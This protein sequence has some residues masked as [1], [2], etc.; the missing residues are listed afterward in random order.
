[1]QRLPLRTRRTFTIALGLAGLLLCA[2]SLVAAAQPVEA[3]THA[4]PP[5]EPVHYQ[6]DAYYPPYTFQSGQFLW[7]FDPYL[8][9]I[10]F[11]TN[12]FAL[13]WS[14]AA[15]DTVYARV[16]SGEI[17]IAGI[18]AITDERKQDVL[19]SKPLFN[20]YV[21]VYTTQNYKTITME[22]LPA[23]RIGVGKGYYTETVLRDTLGI[24]QYSAFDNMENALDA[25]QS[26]EIDVI[27]EN[28]QLM[29]NILIQRNLKGSIVAQITN[30]FP[31]PHAYAISKQKPE[32]VTFINERL[33]QLMA[34]GVFEEIYVKY[35]YTHSDTY[36]EA[37]NRRTLYIAGGVMLAIVSILALMQLI[38]RRLKRSLSVS[39]SNVE[40]ANTQL[41]AANA[42]LRQRYQEIQ[43]LAYTNS[44]TGLP[45]KNEFRQ[46]FVSA[47]PDG[48]TARRV[49]L[50]L[51]L[52]SFKDVND[53]FGH[54]VGD[55][56]LRAVANRLTEIIDPTDRLYNFG[57]DEF[58]VV[59]NDATPVACEGTIKRI[60][61][62]IE[63][64]IMLGGTVFH[65]TACMG[66]AGYPEDGET[67]DELLKNADA[68]MYRA[69]ERGHGT[70]VFFD[71]AI[72]NAVIER[73][74]LQSNL[75]DALSHNEFLLYYQPQINAG[76]KQLYGFEALIRW[77]RPGKGIVAPGAFMDVAEE[78]KLIIPIGNWV[79]TT[80]CEFLKRINDANHTRYTMAVN[81]SVIQLLQEDYTDTV[82]R[83]L[84][85]TQVAPELLELEITESCLLKETELLIDKLKELSG[86]GIRIALDDFGT[87]YSSLRYLKDLPV[88][89]LK[90]DRYFVDS[91]TLERNRALVQAIVSIG[92]A[93]GMAL[94]AEGVETSRQMD[95]TSA[96]QCD[97]IQGFLISKPIP[98]RNVE[99]YIT[100]NLTAE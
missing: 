98:E 79:L 53:T 20:S 8:T 48:D 29:D 95:I 46:S 97:R 11:S 59:L 47:S 96:L 90:I 13:Q 22:D 24:T 50:Y 41:E 73:N 66:V 3:T 84:Q 82:M 33:D 21:S 7:G 4:T 65:I 86:Y 62:Q 45:N 63:K 78:S 35:F 70:F 61:R 92:H 5:P 80:A 26:G 77:D 40:A 87:G 6:V 39:L 76:N 43:A 27:F 72:G 36:L 74:R 83:I 75:R 15:W 12:R 99:G 85:E 49:V 44:V 10:I 67:C 34:N 23:L 58:V 25:L 14:T 57:A 17:D 55:Q 89:V 1:M 52:D 38:I 16:K 64:P 28:Q 30:L 91:I 81:V 54:D 19:F 32:L 18:I 2:C 71:E 9:N 69:K 31:R 93:L 88:H 60:L 100:Q 42:A 68:A 51:D 56:V 37:Q 94:V